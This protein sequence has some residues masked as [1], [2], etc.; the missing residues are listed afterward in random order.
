MASLFTWEQIRSQ[1]RQSRTVTHTCL[2]PHA[3]ATLKDFNYDLSRDKLYFLAHPPP[4]NTGSISRH[5]VVYQVDAH[6]SNKSRSGWVDNDIERQTEKEFLDHVEQLPLLLWSPLF[7]DPSD[8][9]KDISHERPWIH[10]LCSYEYTTDRIML[11][12]SQKIL[13]SHA[14]QTPT[15]LSSH[16][17]GPTAATDPWMHHDPKLGGYQHSMVAFI[18]NNN[19][20]VSTLQGHDIQL[21]F[22]TQ[23][24]PTLNCGTPEYVMQASRGLHEEFRRWTGY[25]WGS[26]TATEN[27]ILY[28][29]TSEEHVEEV[30]LAHTLPSTVPS[31]NNVKHSM[32]YPRA[33]RPNASSCLCLV[34]FNAQGT[35][36]VHK[37]LWQHSIASV[38]PWAEYIV[39]FGWLPNN[40]SVWAQLLSRDQKRTCVVCIPY[41]LWSEE[42]NRNTIEE[43]VV[44]WTETNP[45][46]INI[47]DI[48]YFF[49]TPHASTDFLWSSEMSGYCHL[50]WVSQSHTTTETKCMQITQG[51]WCVVDKPIY[52]DE[53]RQLV[54]FMAR[55]DSSLEDHLYVTS[56]TRPDRYPPL[57][58]TFLGFS[59]SVTLFVEGD[60]FVDVFSNLNCPHITLVG[61]LEFAAEDDYGLPTVRHDRSVRLTGMPPLHQETLWTQSMTKF[62]A[63]YQWP[64]LSVPVSIPVSTPVSTV[65]PLVSP[66]KG[67]LFSFMSSDGLKMHGCLY[68]PFYYCAGVSY[69]CILYVYGGPRCQMVTNDFRFP[70]LL[71]YLMAVYFGFAVVVIDGRGSSD[72]GLVFEAEIQHQ[73]G[74]VELQDQMEG[75]EFLVQTQ[76]GGERTENGKVVSVIDKERIAITGWSYGGYLS[77]L[78]LSRHSSLFK[79][80]IAGA[81]VTQWELYDS[82]YTERYL[83][84]PCENPKGY[85][86]GS[87][88]NSV[89]GFPDSENRLLI[90]HGLMDEN[91]HF[92]HTEALVSL[93][94][95]HK[96]PHYLQIYPTEKHGLRHANVNEHFETLMF[97][98]LM[99]Y[100]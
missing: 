17:H 1:V 11:C 26:C 70:R 52:V 80:A 47:Y 57:R 43:I 90:V 72:R 36:V 76:F 79:V 49:T 8:Y 15:L 99:N 40:K 89:E 81:P 38:F 69:P 21:T 24:H 91:V 95:K 20:W 86:Q 97:H 28:L 31:K 13:L 82:A 84:L 46:W 42:E 74:G 29:E 51:D 6:P 96:K 88:L 85:Q 41:A 93:L 2:F 18:R 27:H 98:W 32:R 63:K 77:L 94:V 67:L 78:G 60:F 44:L 66:P 53:K 45:T 50:Y 92:C 54:Y 30:T 12:C 55:K 14:L 83:G 34:V 19:L 48:C 16:S 3:W 61:Y 75:L 4:T 9:K 58:L 10:D 35:H 73:L 7:H 5:L 100:L 22:C 62:I 25:Y 87:V 56:Y 59:H 65:S 37:R 23:N 68:R 71:R 39:R 33:G 64:L